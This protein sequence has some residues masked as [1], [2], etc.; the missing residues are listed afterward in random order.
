MGEPSECLDYLSKVSGISDAQAHIPVSSTVRSD[1]STL[2][3]PGSTPDTSTSWTGSLIYAE[4]SATNITDG[5]AWAMT[6]SIRSICL[7]GKNLSLSSS[8][9]FISLIRLGMCHEKLRPE[10]P[11]FAIQ[12]YAT[13]IPLLNVIEFE[14]PRTLTAPASPSSFSQ[15]RELWRWVERHMFRVITLLART[16]HLDDQGLI[17][18]FFTRYESCSTHWPPTFRTSHRSIITILH[19]RALIIRFRVSPPPVTPVASLQPEKP[20]Q[21][22]NTARSIINEYRT[23]LDKCTHFPKAGERNV[24]VEDLVDLSVAVW[25]ASG[26]AADRVQ[27][28]I[29]VS[30]PSLCAPQFLNN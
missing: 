22:V 7:Q 10:D 13:A 17:W 19:L 16:R 25:E 14:I 1:G 8:L 24:K 4:P 11:E 5:R 28:V 26:A 27:W 12:T 3:P 15:Y 21:W 2:Q 23:I 18:N 20:P 9:D 6:E 29:D 30:E